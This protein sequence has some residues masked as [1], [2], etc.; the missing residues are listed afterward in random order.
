M[1]EKREST[2]TNNEIDQMFG[3][4][5]RD[6]KVGIKKFFSYKLFLN[7][8]KKRNIKEWKY[9]KKTKKLIKQKNAISY[10]RMC[11]MGS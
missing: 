2:D 3:L 1:N 10:L 5:E 4:S 7:N 11:W 8:N 9:G 6:F